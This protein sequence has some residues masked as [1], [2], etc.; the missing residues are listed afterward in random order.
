MPFLTNK[1]AKNCYVLYFDT[2]AVEERRKFS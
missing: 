1:N 2:D